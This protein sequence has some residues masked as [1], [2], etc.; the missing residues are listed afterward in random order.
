MAPPRSKTPTVTHRVVQKF[1]EKTAMAVVI[2]N[3]ADHDWGWFS[4]ED[5]RMHLQTV[6]EGA[7]SGPKR[8]KVWL[9]D[10]GKRICTLDDGKVSGSDLRKLW[11]KIKAE[12]ANIESR[13]I[14]FMIQNGWLKAE[15]AGSVVTLTAYPKSHNKFTRTIDLREEFPGAYSDRVVEPWDEHPPK[16]ALDGKHAALAVGREVALDD[17]SH[18]DLTKWIFED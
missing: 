8:A 5:E 4:R 11:A 13:W 17:R 9:E 18:I 1:K 7:R 12:R 16:I 3:I 14:H 10:R 6:E 15:L 2:R